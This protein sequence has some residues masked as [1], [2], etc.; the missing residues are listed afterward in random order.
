MSLGRTTIDV[1]K[2]LD[3]N[4][5]QAQES[6]VQLNVQLTQLANVIHRIEENMS[7]LPKIDEE[8]KR[9]MRIRK[10]MLNTQTI[11]AGV[12]FRLER[13]QNSMNE[14]MK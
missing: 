8:V 14:I 2:Q 4:F 7:Q 12:N 3:K 10:R 5:A 6:Q 13:T 1:I 9:L 11:L